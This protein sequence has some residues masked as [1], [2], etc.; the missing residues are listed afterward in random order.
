MEAHKAQTKEWPALHNGKFRMYDDGRKEAMFVST[1]EWEM[2]DLEFTCAI[3]YMNIILIDCFSN[4]S[5]LK[6]EYRSLSVESAFYQDY[7]NYIWSLHD[8]QTDS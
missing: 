2:S 4:N 3:R 6:G 5:R 7:L 1:T 8:H